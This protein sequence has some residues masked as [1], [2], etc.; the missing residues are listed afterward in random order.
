[1]EKYVKDYYFINQGRQTPTLYGFTQKKISLWSQ[2]WCS[3]TEMGSWIERPVLQ[4]VTQGSRV[5][6]SSIYI[7]R[8]PRL[9]WRSTSRQQ[10][11]EE[12]V[13]WGARA[14]SGTQHSCPCS[15]SQNSISWPCSLQRGLGNLVSA[16]FQEEEE[17]ASQRQHTSM[18]SP[19]SS[20]IRTPQCPFINW[21]NINELKT[22]LI[23]FN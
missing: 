22:F 21:G 10:I 5:M 3:W 9:P 14:G 1:M 2:N 18:K 17:T 16:C 4:G 13:V 15:I 6:T 23:F 11:K 12:K 8:L 7:T 20:N 19:G